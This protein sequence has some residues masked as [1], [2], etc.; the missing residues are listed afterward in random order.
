MEDIFVHNRR[1]G[2]TER[3]SKHSNGDEGDSNSYDPSISYNGRYVAF[4]SQA[5]NLVNNDT[6]GST[7]VFQRRVS[8][9]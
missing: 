5:T 4:T 7:D 9:R 2:K 6:N 8:K 3:V 1:T